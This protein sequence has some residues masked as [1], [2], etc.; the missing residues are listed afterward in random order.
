MHL[1]KIAGLITDSETDLLLAGEAQRLHGLLEMATGDAGLAAQH[2]GRSV[3]I[4]DLLGDRYRSARA[5]YEL[6]RAYALAQPDRAAE[7]FARATNIFRELGARLD[8]AQTEAARTAL[9][10]STAEQSR[11]SE[12][13]A[14]LLTLRLAEAVA[15]RELLL[16]ELAAVIRQETNCASVVVFE[17]HSEDKQRV[18]I[19]HGLD[20]HE[21]AA[22]AKQFAAVHSS[23]QLES[24]ARK[25]DAVVINF[26]FKQCATCHADDFAA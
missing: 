23:T 18:V 13:V 21:S 16:H 22:L 7:H 5:H 1:Q 20:Q 2:F 25:H 4:F 8:L 17:P 12:T 24:F 19:A 9:D 6:G 15:S 10:G 3:S 14:Q 11:Q 26:E